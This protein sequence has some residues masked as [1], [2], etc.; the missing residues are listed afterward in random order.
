MRAARSSRPPSRRRAGVARGGGRGPPTRPADD[1]L[2]RV[3]GH[4]RDAA[5]A[6]QRGPL[7]ARERRERGHRVDRPGQRPD[8]DPLGVCENARREVPGPRSSPVPHPA[9]ASKAP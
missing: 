9:D 6:H 8:R 7:P 2:G 5:V 4:R 1:D 3:G